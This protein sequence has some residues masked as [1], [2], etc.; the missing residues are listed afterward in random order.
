MT[1]T[2]L[3]LEGMRFAV[4][5]AVEGFGDFLMQFD[6]VEFKV[7]RH[8]T[9][10]QPFIMM[11]VWLYTPIRQVTDNGEGQQLQEAVIREL[12]INF[13]G[14][15]F[16]WQGGFSGGNTKGWDMWRS[17]EFP[18]EA[19]AD[20]SFEEPYHLFLFERHTTTEQS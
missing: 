15:A 12:G 9:N 16:Q 17:V 2:K 18:P 1:T 19:G 8:S 20:L 3:T 11:S 4:L 7:V 13:P 10:S 6:K 14:V 5:S